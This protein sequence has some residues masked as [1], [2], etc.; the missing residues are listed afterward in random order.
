MYHPTKGIIKKQGAERY[1]LINRWG[2][3]QV[4]AVNGDCSWDVVFR[5]KSVR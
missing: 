3:V 1:L 5:I 4:V 2:I